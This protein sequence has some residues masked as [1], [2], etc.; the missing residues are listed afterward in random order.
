MKFEIV[1]ATSL[2]CLALFTVSPISRSSHK[3]LDAQSF[4]LSL[5]RPEIGLCVEYEG[6]NSVWI[7]H[8]NL[9]AGYA[10]EQWNRTIAD[11]ITST[12][13][14]LAVEYDLVCNSE[15]VPIDTRAEIL[16]GYN[17]HALNETGVRIVDPSY[18]GYALRNEEATNKAFE[19]WMNYADLVIYQA[20]TELKKQD[21]TYA[22][23]LYDM[24]KQFWDGKGFNDKAAR[25]HGYYDVYKLGL[26][27]YL[28]RIMG[29]GHFEFEEVLVERTW[30]CQASNGGFL[31]EYYGNGSIPD[32]TKANCETTAIILL[33]NMPETVA[34]TYEDGD[35]WQDPKTLV[36]TVEAAIIIALAVKCVFRRR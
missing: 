35:W 6:S 5:Y 2:L 16:L 30:S 15:N 34:E 11:N 19:D 1:V 20:L 31:T 3:M 14:H 27:Y 36:I 26:F 23:Q 12:V 13:K 8:D 28:N 9:L 21:Y 17:V 10:M 4:L 33:A 32:G 25:L 18:H 24:A 29:K 22:D 7:T